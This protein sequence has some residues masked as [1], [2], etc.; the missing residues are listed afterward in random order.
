MTSIEDVT[1]AIQIA[2]IIF[3]TAE[4]AEGVSQAGCKGATH[5]DPHSIQENKKASRY[6]ACTQ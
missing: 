6:Q 4:I 1:D 5:T 2:E 3:K